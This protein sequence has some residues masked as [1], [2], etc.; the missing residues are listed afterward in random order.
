MADSANDLSGYLCDCPLCGES[1]FDY[2][3]GYVEFKRGYAHREC[4]L[5]WA[6]DMCGYQPAWEDEID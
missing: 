6:E 1:I 3:P 5:E 4:L 2:E